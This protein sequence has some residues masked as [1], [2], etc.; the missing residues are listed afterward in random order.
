MKRIY[1]RASFQKYLESLPQ[2]KT[3]CNRYECPISQFSKDILNN[4]ISVI[5]ASTL[6]PVF[7]HALDDSDK[8]ITAGNDWS[9]ITASYALKILKTL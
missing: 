7:T 2:A 4:P 9:R 1:L 5:R 3:F 6:D 8:H